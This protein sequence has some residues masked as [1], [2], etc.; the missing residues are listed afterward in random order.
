MDNAY[1][2]DHPKE[3][4]RLIQSAVA[5]C[6]DIEVA[7]IERPLQRVIDVDSLMS[8]WWPTNRFPYDANGTL[9]FQYYDCKITVTSDGVVRAKLRPE[10]NRESIV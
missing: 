1:T 2:A 3:V 9:T 6:H 5:D 7:E 4:P 10:K 8:L